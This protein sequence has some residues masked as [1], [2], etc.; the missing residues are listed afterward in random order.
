MNRIKK[1]TDI[2]YNTNTK[3]D[4]TIIH[5]SDIHFN[6]NTSLSKLNKLTTEIKKNNPD[7]IMISGDLIDE[8]KII[9]NKYK[10]KELLQFLSNLSEITKIFISLGNHDIFSSED[11]KFFN[12]LNELK[13]IYILDNDCYKD[14]FI[15]ISG[16]TLPNNYYYNITH[17]ESSEVLVKHLTNNRKLISKLPRELPKV[18]LIHSPIKL[19]NKEVLNKLKEYDLILSGHT[20]NGMVPGILKSLFPKNKGLIAPN[21][22]LFPEIAKG[23]IEVNQDNKKITIII[24]GAITKLSSKSSKIL[25]KLN[26]VYP[27]SINKI[28][29]TKKRGKYYE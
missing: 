1:T 21:K 4:L 27:M 2:V 8:P 5:I 20:H 15:Y 10:I 29:I 22:T 12:K 3:K 28:I 23:K 24:N 16:L 14:E 11:L 17:E 19:T 9:K 25:S 26:I 13:N 18:I 7:Y 6:T